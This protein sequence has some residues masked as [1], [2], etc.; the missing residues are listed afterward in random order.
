MIVDKGD[1]TGK[2]V[3][4]EKSL[5][6]GASDLARAQAVKEGIT[7]ACRIQCKAQII[8]RAIEARWMMMRAEVDAQRGK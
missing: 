2:G 5:A 6:S 1:A 8:K 3:R 4:G 7:T